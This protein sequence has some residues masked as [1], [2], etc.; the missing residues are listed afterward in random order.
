MNILI[1]TILALN[2][3]ADF[4]PEIVQ[5]GFSYRIVIAASSRCDI[6]GKK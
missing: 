2:P 3:P 6:R 1:A 5:F 4:P